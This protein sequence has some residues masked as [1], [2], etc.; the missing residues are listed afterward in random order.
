MWLLHLHSKPQ[1]RT[2]LEEKHKIIPEMRPRKELVTSL[3]EYKGDIDGIIEELSQYSYDSEQLVV[4]TRRHLVN[5]LE[6]FL[7]DEFLSSEVQFW[8][9]AIETRE[10]I[11]YEIGYEGI[12]T[13][14]LLKL[15]QFQLEGTLDEDSAKQMMLE[16]ARTQTN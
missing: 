5:V 9:D 16:L 15:S 4:L 14:A 7:E 3:I 11:Q 10:D 13:D 6:R 12:I 8:A 1:Q 2:Q